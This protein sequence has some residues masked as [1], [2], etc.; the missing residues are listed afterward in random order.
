[1]R[2]TISFAVAAGLLVLLATQAF[3]TIVEPAGG[4]LS[5]N[6]QGLGFQTISETTLVNPGDLVMVDF[7]GSANLFF[8]DGCKIVLQ[9]GSVMTIGPLSPCAA[10]SLAQGQAQEGPPGGSPL[11]PVGASAFTAA[12]LGAGGFVAYEI[13]HKTT[14]A[15]HPASP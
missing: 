2:R 11:D 7:Y 12:A 6:R 13:F 1:M 4:T 5:I 15:P 9:P 3:A 10:K 8:P 14:P